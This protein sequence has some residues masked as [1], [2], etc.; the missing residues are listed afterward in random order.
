MATDVLPADLTDDLPRPSWQNPRPKAASRG[1][2]VRLLAPLASLKLTVALF[3]LAI[4]LIFAGTLAQASHDV[5]WVLHNYFRSF[6][7]WIDFQV[8]FPPAWFP[9][10]QDWHGGFYFPGGFLIGSA[11]AVNLLAAHG[12]RF[13]IQA[14]GARLWSGVAVIAAGCLFLWLII[15]AGPGG[16]GVQATMP[17]DWKTI[18]QLFL[19]GL[20][21]TCVGI[22][23]AVMMLGRERKVERLVLEVV[24]A[25]L[26]ALLAYL[27]FKIDANAINS[28]S[29]RSAVRILWQVIEAGAAAL[30]LLAGC[31][32]VFRKRAGIVLLHAGIILIMGNELVVRF[33]HKEAQMSITE[34][35]TTNFASDI[36]SIELAVIDANP[37]SAKDNVVVV[38]DSILNQSLANKHPVT[39]A[40][41]PFD[42]EMT[43]FYENAQL[44]LAAAGEE[45]PVDAGAGRALRVIEERPVTGA[46][47]KENGNLPAAYV[48]LTDK[49]TSR[50]LGTYL[51]GILLAPQKVKVGDKEYELALR[52]QRDYK[53]YTMH[54]DQVRADMYLG[55]AIPRNYESKLHLVDPSRGTDRDVDIRM[56]EPFR[57]G[58]E[59]FYQSG[60]HLDPATGVG[61]TTL[62]VVT[63]FGWMIP[64]AACMIVA[65][66]MLS[67]FSQVLVRFLRRRDQGRFASRGASVAI[68]RPSAATA[69]LATKGLAVDRADPRWATALPIVAVALA[70]GL[71]IYTAL[72]PSTPRDEID[73]YSFGKLPV[74]MGGRVQ[75]ID[76][77]ARNSLRM[78]SLRET[79]L[80]APGMLWKPTDK[81]LAIEGV[82][83]DTPAAAAG[84]QPGDAITE[85]AGHPIGTLTADEVSKWL[86]GTKSPIV[87]LTVVRGGGPPLVRTIRREY[88]PA[89]KWLLD[90]A[91]RPDI[92]EQQRIF[93]IENLDVLSM[94]GLKRREYFRYSW[95]EINQHNDD[96]EAAREK[97]KG[98]E[99]SG[100]SVFEKKLAEL[101]SRIDTYQ[102]LLFTFMH[103]RI[104]Q[105]PTD[106]EIKA[107][108]EAA[109]KTMAEIKDQLLK[110]PRLSDLLTEYHAPLVVPPL[111]AE[112]HKTSDTDDKT[113][114]DASDADRPWQPYSVAWMIDY[115]MKIRGQPVNPATSGWEAIFDGYSDNDAHAF[116]RAVRNYSELLQDQPPQA[117][118][119]VNPTF[120][121]WF[122]YW[123]PFANCQ[124][125]YFGAFCLAVL[126]WLGW[127][128]PLNRAAFWLIA[129]TFVVHTAGLVARMYISGRPPITNLYA[130]AIY[131]GWAAVLAGLI[132]ES[133]YR[134][135]F[136]NVM[137]AVAGFASLLVADKL[138]LLTSE[139]HGDTIGV[140]Q[141]VLDTQ[142]WLATHV[143]CVVTGYTATYVAGLLGMIYVVRGV[144]TSS[145]NQ[146]DSKD[147]ARMIYGTVCFGLFFSFVGTVLGG[148]W[149]DNSW[150]RFWGWDPKENAALIIVIWNA[151]VLHARWDGM[152]KDRGLAV[153]A[154]GGNIFASW[155]HF[156][157]NQL[158]VGLHSY[159]FT[160][161]VLVALGLFCASQ[162]AFI[163][164]GLLPRRL[165]RSGGAS[166]AVGAA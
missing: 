42:V 16:D 61:T 86:V 157:V 30:V 62:Q 122:N 12:I 79:Y 159:G 158:G 103:R 120:E 162:L 154:I 23:A 131:I 56:N 139:S 135:G 6:Y 9:N 22:A 64:Y 32:L 25:L 126:A 31:I 3:A 150:G 20:G 55:T 74:E 91:V 104:P 83:Q 17:L 132:L 75:P 72:P 44:G 2:L 43:K 115:V 99:S 40:S 137:A 26:L 68:H 112:D 7:V 28:D 89:V 95:A 93:R 110:L 10:W 46:D 164:L 80:E 59:T 94:L 108:P 34:G 73:L 128:G 11:M 38:P 145:F 166:G 134:I 60:Y 5:W 155:S 82:L 165:W 54:L 109:N 84:L 57:Y 63:N 69:K 85:I 52:F 143:T 49:E 81:T 107:D 138:A 24:G 41:L 116:N 125:L 29:M 111:K 152:V 19:V 114:A 97:L 161:G 50:P 33:L 76:S 21:L 124:W 98:R 127:S 51:V 129:V 144:F 160:E 142:F 1:A 123:G 117:L 66:G 146:A 148:L 4:F 105:P 36:R 58:G 118:A 96:M 67:H 163:A 102:V 100:Y 136:G 48:K 15:V 37:D 78:I 121:A 101:S 77:L 8:F 140:I 45:N 153:L 156:G 47:T 92:A 149:A 35:H 133:V 87:E 13:K 130:T 88:Q 18:W 106:E 71:L 27:V 141:A 147:L 14:A 53:P 39:N 70:A 151:L 119:D 65:I 113:P 90:L